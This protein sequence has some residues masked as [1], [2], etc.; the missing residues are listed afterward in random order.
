[1]SNRSAAIVVLCLLASLPATVARAQ[2]TATGDVA[3]SYSYLRFQEG[4]GYDVPA[5]W[6]L[7]ASWRFAP[8]LSVVGQGSGNYRSED[9]QWLMVHSYM[10]G[11]RVSSGSRAAIRPY[12]EFLAGAA[13]GSCCGVGS[14]TKFAIEPGGGVDFALATR[15]AVRLGVGFPMILADEDT[16]NLFRLQ[17]GVVFRVG[18]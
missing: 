15:T 13:T 3:V 18:G 9:D 17:I 2:D 10:G 5:G 16:T 4:D 11:L 12:A 8:L 1:M 14:E 6:L 7:S